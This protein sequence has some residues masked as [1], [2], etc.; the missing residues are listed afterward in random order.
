MQRHVPALLL[1]SSALLAAA[2]GSDDA[3]KSKLPVEKTAEA[4][5][6]YKQVVSLN[7]AEVLST[8][9]ALKVAIDAFVAAPS[10][11]SHKA[12]KDAWVAARLP[13]APSEAFRFYD[14]PIDNPET[15]PEGLINGWPLDEN[16][17]D[18]TRDDAAAG[19]IND[20]TRVPTITVDVIKGSNEVG[21]EKNL[22]TGYHAIEFLL[23]GQDDKEPGS[24]A[25]K[26]PYT[27]YVVG[28]TAQNQQRRGDYLK[29]VTELL[30][31][32][33]NQ[34]DD[35]WKPG[36]AGN[37][38]ASYGVSADDKET[39]VSDQLKAIGSMAKAELS[40]ERMTVA[41]VNRN[42]EDEHSCFSDNT[43]PDILG[44]AE[45]LQNVWLG[46]YKGFDGVGLDEVVAA[47]DPTLASKTTAD[48]GDAVSKLKALVDLQNAGT[49]IDVI[50]QATDDSPGRVAM[51]AGIRS[52]KVVAD[53]ME[54]AAKA[55]GVSIELEQPSTEL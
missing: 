21:G 44:D 17:I 42:Q 26:R 30:V 48:L 34:V 50:L 55:L 54:A 10:E 23:W 4:L 12:A 38:A 8:A 46:R 37:F 5:T 43:A 19:I 39:F 32:D 6:A 35:A 11:A 52:L 28:G 36:V 24:G 20:L 47:V 45:G 15:G 25:G 51:L 29:L 27:D 31:S 14:G 1:V 16:Y 33:L 7:Y 13:Y 2:C 53:D 41:Y 9:T 18:Y 22:S 40:G 3:P 49:P